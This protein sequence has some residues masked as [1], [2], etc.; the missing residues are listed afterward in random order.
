MLLEK[1]KTRIAWL[2][3]SAVATMFLLIAFFKAI[4][5]YDFETTGIA[6]GGTLV[7]TGNKTLEILQYFRRHRKNKATKETTNRNYSYSSF[8]IMILFVCVP[9]TILVWQGIKP[10]SLSTFTIYL[11]AAKIIFVTYANPLVND[12]LNID[13]TGEPPP[14]NTAIL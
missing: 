6:V 12:L 11:V 1:I 5:F 4:E 9:L 8:L 3:I 2:Y 14:D 13:D 10:F 7:F